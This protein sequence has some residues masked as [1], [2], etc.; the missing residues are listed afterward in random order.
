MEDDNKD[1]LRIALI[2]CGRIA[3][4]HAELL[5]NKK[6]HQVELT[7]VC[8]KKIERAKVDLSFARYNNEGFTSQIIK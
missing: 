3:H 8:D 7:A 1:T 5:G 6:I 4:R 2:G